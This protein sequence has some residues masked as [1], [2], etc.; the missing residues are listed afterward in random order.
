MTQTEK[1]TDVILESGITEDA[2]SGRERL[3]KNIIYNAFV[4]KYPSWD[5]WK[6]DRYVKDI[7]KN[8]IFT[9]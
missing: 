5:M 7:Y 1:G 8:I 2:T 9:Y 3:L 6:I 4:W